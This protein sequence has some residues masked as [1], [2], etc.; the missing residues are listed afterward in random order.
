MITVLA[1]IPLLAAAAALPGQ[2]DS[3]CR[4]HCDALAVQDGKV[5]FIDQWPPARTLDLGKYQPAAQ[6]LVPRTEAPILD[7]HSP[8]G[9]HII[10]SVYLD[11]EEDEPETHVR[12]FSPDGM[13]RATQNVLLSVEGTELGKLFGDSDEVFAIASWEEHAYN[14]Q[15][16]IWLLP[17]VG[18]PTLLLDI[19]G[20]FQRFLSGAQGNA[21]G[22]TV[23]RQTYDGVHA[24]TKGALEE[25]Y[26]WNPTTKSLKLQVR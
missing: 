6:A 26:A 12:F 10:V 15:S 21:A 25:F 7:L 18:A 4:E 5:R 2:I 23:A 9:W 14:V 17:A 1:M 13:L 3:I 11:H 8:R 22:V 16:K 19:P 20:V 24:D